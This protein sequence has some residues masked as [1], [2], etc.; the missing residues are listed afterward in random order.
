MDDP[1]RLLPLSPAVFHILLVL[2]DGELHGYGIMQ[3]I[4]Q[5]TNG[6]VN[7]GPG[8]LYRSI[9]QMIDQNL[10]VEADERVDAKLSDERRRYYRL[11]EYGQRVAQAEA[12]RLALLVRI[13]QQ[14]RLIGGA[15]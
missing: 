12:E 9:K 10:I 4:A 3:Q 2:A 14:R 6:A 11:T 15:T 5:M 13:A 1:N 8:P 7:I